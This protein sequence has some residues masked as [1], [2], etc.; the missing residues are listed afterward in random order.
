MEE[1]RMSQAG[2][3]ELVKR[4]YG[5]YHKARKQERGRILTEFVKVSA[6]H[7]KSAIRMLNRVVES[8]SEKSTARRSYGKTVYESSTIKIIEQVW[9]T[10]GYPWSV[11]L[12]AALSEWMP[13]IRKRFGCSPA[14][15]EQLLR[16]SARQIDRRLKDKKRMIKRRFYGTTKPG[17]LLKSQIPIRVKSW[18]IRK[19]GYLEIDTVAHCGSSLSGEFIYT[20][21]SVDIRSTWVERQA[22]LGKGESAALQGMQQI[23]ARLPFALRGIDSDNGSEFINH[24]L[25][26][27]CKKQRLEFTRARPQESKDQAHIEQKNFTH[28][29]KMLGWQRYSS[30][31]ALD[32][33][34]ALYAG[35]LRQLD[36]LF[37]PSVKLKSKL[38]LGSKIVRRYFPACSPLTR[39]RDCLGEGDPKVQELLALRASLDPFELAEIIDQLLVKIQ[40]LAQKKVPLNAPANNTFKRPDYFIT[41]KQKKRV[42]ALRGI[43]KM[44]IQELEPKSNF[45]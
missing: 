27:Y 31:S 14:V 6:M 37:C 10:M 35:P 43:I 3:Q 11:R 24:S 36:N 1:H 25:W 41:L 26:N 38:R 7:R 42:L 34:N 5:R 20:L 16:I 17:Y 18:D 39:L 15:C 45:R 2:R 23:Q 30:Q 12:K 9:E 28:V 19:P 44:P 40:S 8:S 4:I 32:L 29:R 22:I 33:I 21:N 13:Y